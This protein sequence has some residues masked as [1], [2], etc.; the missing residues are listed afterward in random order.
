MRSAHSYATALFNNANKDLSSAKQTYSH[1]LQIDEWLTK[2]KELTLLIQNPLHDIAAIK[3]VIT[4]LCAKSTIDKVVE[5]FLL[6]L[7]EVKKI[8]LLPDIIQ[9]YKEI[10]YKKNNIA[11]AKIEARSKIAPNLCKQITTILEE[12]LN[13]K[14]VIEHSS[15]DRLIGGFKVHVDGKLID[16]SVK[17]Q[18]DKLIL[19]L[20]NK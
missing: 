6:N 20:A 7:A 14:I 17:N 4:Q 11:I 2:S 19:H 9:Y 18:I 10:Y 5:K 3:E 12:K 15:N 16:Y 8:N 13:K 1:V